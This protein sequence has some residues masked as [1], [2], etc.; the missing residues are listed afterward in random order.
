M[1][2]ATEKQRKLFGIAR[3]IQKG[4]TSARYSPTAAKVAKTVNP[5]K[6]REFARK[7]KKWRSSDGGRTKM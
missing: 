3:A 7:K 6:V 1:P 4:E 5:E 2:A